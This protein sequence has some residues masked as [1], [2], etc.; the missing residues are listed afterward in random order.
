[1]QFYEDKQPFI[2]T[3]SM[4]L[5]SIQEQTFLFDGSNVGDSFSRFRK[6]QYT[7]FTFTQQEVKWPFIEYTSLKI[8]HIFS[9]LGDA[10]CFFVFCFIESSIYPHRVPHTMNP[11][12]HFVLVT[13]I[14]IY[15]DNATWVFSISAHLTN[16]A[17][18][19]FVPNDYFKNVC[20]VDSLGR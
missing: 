3:F 13:H 10:Q 5:Q 17:L 15:C 7:T 8:L 2:F 12:P 6:H 18:T 1:M 19:A 20:I 16:K 9:P 14:R 4:Y 11:S